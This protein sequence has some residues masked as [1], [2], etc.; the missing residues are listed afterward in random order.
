MTCNTNEVMRQVKT[1]YAIK[2]ADKTPQRGRRRE[3]ENEEGKELM[4]KGSKKR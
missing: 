3:E 1:N 2:E 4:R